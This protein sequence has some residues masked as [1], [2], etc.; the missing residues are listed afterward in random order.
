MTAARERGRFRRAR[1]A[2]LLLTVLQLAGLVQPSLVHAGDAEPP[3]EYSAVKE[4]RERFQRGVRFYREGNDDAALAEFVRAQELAPNFRILYNLGQVQA[5]RNDAVAALRFFKQYL[6]EGGALI[7]AERKSEVERSLLELQEKVAELQIEADAPGARL[8][9]NDTFIAEL[10]LPKPLTIN[11]GKCNLRLERDG[12]T[13]VTRELVVA[14]GELRVV[15]LTLTPE[16]KPAPPPLPPPAEPVSWDE[17]PFW[18]SLAATA[19]LGTA[20]AAFAFATAFTDRPEVA[21][22]ADQARDGH[23]RLRTYALLTG[24]FGAATLVS[25]GA[26]AYFLLSR[27]SDSSRK[28]EASV[29]AKVVPSPSGVYLLGTF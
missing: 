5:E 28:D 23:D 15:S 25:A 9:V 21:A 7:S 14:S 12:Y 18:I 4:A 13:P 10:P 2:L 29:T 22:D 3:R 26:A 27:P 11:A 8:F 16:A 20:T 1:S 6:L 17:R 19:S 24:S